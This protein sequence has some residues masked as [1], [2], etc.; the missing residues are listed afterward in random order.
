MARVLFYLPVV[1][2]WW[3]DNI[4]APLIRSLA[5]AS[6][7]HILV[8]PLWRNTGIGPA[9]VEGCSTVPG[10][11]WHIVHDPNHQ[12][13]RTSPADADGVVEFVQNIAPDYVFCRSA[14]IAT[15]GRFPGQV[16]HLLEAGASPFTIPAT[17]VIL[18]RDFWH[19]G[20]MPALREEDAGAVRSAFADTWQ[21]IRG[22]FDPCGEPSDRVLA[23]LGLPQDRKVLALPLEYEHEEAFTTFH[24]QFERNVDLIHHLAEKLSDEYVLA[25]T[26]HPLNYKH[27][28][29]SETHAAIEALGPRAHLLPNPAASSSPTDLLI[30]HCA[31]LV[32]QNTKAIYS[33]AFFGK[34]TLR[35]SNRP[36]AE[37]IHAHDCMEGFLN[38][39]ASGGGGAAVDQAQL[40]FG[41]HLMHEVVDPATISGAEILHRIDQ[42][43]SLGRIEGGLARLE[44]HLRGLNKAV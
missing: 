12:S 3:F 44:G 40:W 6:E 26:D 17:W 28:D 32:V 15:P 9:Q 10:L 42:P 8:P 18:Q 23:D 24:N 21:R 5:A 39:I 11:Q 22:R 38:Q 19:H 1:T 16:I 14:D 31:G 29:N 4:V 35:L 36:T 25:I 7:V 13:L 34:P 37:W 2:P 43:L 27:V 41:F 33:G 30:K 20:A